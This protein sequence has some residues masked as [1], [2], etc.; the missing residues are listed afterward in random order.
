MYSTKKLDNKKKSTQLGYWQGK[1][2]NDYT[3]RN[4]D[5]SIFRKRKS[6]FRKLLQKTPTVRTVLEVGC[7]MGG[8]LLMLHE[9]QKNL[10][11]HGLEPNI[12]AAHQARKLL[13]SATISNKSVLD[14]AWRKKLDL[15]FTC[16]VLIHIND[17]DIKNAMKKIYTA[18]HEYILSIEYYSPTSETIFYRGLSDALFKRPYDTMW[19]NQFPSLERRAEGYLSRE[20]G[21]DNC[22]WWLFRK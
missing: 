14:I 9:I 10:R 22:H 7:N 20:Q 15:S 21:F 3:K 19:Q 4:S 1:F 18:T 8:N 13:P 12:S 16:G 6:F 17:S 2:G 5:L 11:L